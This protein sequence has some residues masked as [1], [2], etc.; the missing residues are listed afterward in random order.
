MMDLRAIAIGGIATFCAGLGVGWQFFGYP[1]GF[2]AGVEAKRV[3]YEALWSA[4]VRITGEREQCKG[5]IVKVNTEVD[6]Q[7]EENRKIL[8]DDRAVTS[9]AIERAER[10]AIDAA[11]ASAKTQIQLAEA[12]YELGKI[13]DACVN[14]GVPSAYFDVLN[15]A[16]AGTHADGS[17]QR[18]VPGGKADN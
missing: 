1:R 8:I 18:K 3:E 4:S 16:L 7:K 12:A 6:R 2:D 10:A 5:E 9:K 13:K 14:A 17:V 11:S 15:K